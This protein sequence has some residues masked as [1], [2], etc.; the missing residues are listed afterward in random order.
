MLRVNGKNEYLNGTDV[1]ARTNAAAAADGGGA[2]LEIAT[3][4]A[5]AADAMTSREPHQREAAAVSRP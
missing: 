1:P 3:T 5:A 2:G 4:D